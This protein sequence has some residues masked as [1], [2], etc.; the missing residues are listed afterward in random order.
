MLLGKKVL[1]PK[2]KCFNFSNKKTSVNCNKVKKV[3]IVVVT[4]N[5]YV[6]VMI[7]VLQF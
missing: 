5:F 2:N 6:D 1:C 7:Q 4:K 3:S